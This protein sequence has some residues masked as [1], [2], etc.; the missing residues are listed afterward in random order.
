MIRRFSLPIALAALAL[1]QLASA[2]GKPDEIKELQRDVAVL[3]DLV[4]Q[5][6][7][8]QD[9]KFADLVAATQQAAESA[10]RA[11]TAIDAIKLSLQQSL[12]TQE[13]KV[14]APVV[15]LSTR[16]DNV[17]R[18]LQTTEQNLNDLSA[19]ITKILAM[20]DD[21]NKAIK[22]IQMPPPP[23]APDAGAATPQPGAGS[24]TVPP[25]S[26]PQPA[27]APGPPPG[28]SLDMYNNALHDYQAGNYDMA[29]TE[30]ADYLKYFEKGAF[31]SNAQ[32]YIGMVH[33]A[34]QD[35]ATAKD[36][37]DTV[38]E[39]YPE[40]ANKNADARYFKGMSLLRLGK[41]TEAGAEFRDLILHKR[42][43]PLAPQACHQLEALGM[44]CPPPPAP[45]SKKGSGKK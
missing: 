21:M 7:L 6:Q 28:S 35:Y 25:G 34:K 30:F 39:K 4:K 15:G 11:N 17:T 33:Y 27:V 42:S 8:T 24:A 12:R 36:D 1:P 18:E 13:E 37:F 14:V 16:M 22:V 29:L 5:L 23:P 3:Q 38:L 31:A 10:S 2:A 19:Q 9:K 20:L 40:T 45:A 41:K 26:Q 44:H 32:Y 43:D